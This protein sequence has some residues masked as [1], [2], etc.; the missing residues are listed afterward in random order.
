MVALEVLLVFLEASAETF[1]EAVA[2]D[3]PENFL[4]AVQAGFQP[5]LVRFPEAGLHH[6]V[7]KQLGSEGLARYSHEVRLRN[8]CLSATL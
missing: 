4:E 3:S 8:R 7:G 2:V 1:L 5:W 6:E